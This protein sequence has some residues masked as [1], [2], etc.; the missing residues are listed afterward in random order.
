MRWYVFE[1]FEVYNIPKLKFDQQ[2]NT[3]QQSNFE[4]QRITFVEAEACSGMHAIGDT[5]LNSKLIV[6]FSRIFL[7]KPPQRV[8]VAKSQRDHTYA[9]S[10]YLV[11]GADKYPWHTHGY[12]LA[13]KTNRASFLEVRQRRGS[14]PASP[15]SGFYCEFEFC[16][17]WRVLPVQSILNCRQ[18]LPAQ[19]LSS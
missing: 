11:V 14:N 6:E 1:K 7:Q 15:W 18:K 8:T 5:N 2:K 17:V 19:A 4:V 3:V 12:G 16:S 13:M 10:Q 9:P